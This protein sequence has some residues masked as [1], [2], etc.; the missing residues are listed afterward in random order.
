MKP[1]SSFNRFKTL[2]VASGR[3]LRTVEITFNSA[4]AGTMMLLA[5]FVSSHFPPLPMK[6]DTHGAVPATSSW[7][8]AG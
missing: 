7:W 3:I 6:T 4:T 2:I 8:M 1:T 5:D